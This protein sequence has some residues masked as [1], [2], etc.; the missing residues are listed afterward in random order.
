MNMFASET[1]SN[2]DGVI[3]FTP[4]YAANVVFLTLFV[5][6]F[7]GHVGLAIR[8]WRCYGYTI[9]MICGL[10][11]EFLGYLAKVRLSR[12]REDQSSYIM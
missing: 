2:N 10:L 8:Y 4:Q 12:N 11:L 9:G 7:A 1:Y 6:L 3:S 5:L